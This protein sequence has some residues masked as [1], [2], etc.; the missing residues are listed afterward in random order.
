MADWSNLSR[1]LESGYIMGRQ[2]GGKLSTL[3][4]NIAILADRLKSQREAGEEQ[5]RKINLLGVEGL[6]KEKL[7]EK[8]ASLKPTMQPIVDKTGKI[9]GYR[10]VGAVFQPSSM[11][12][13]D[14]TNPEVQPPSKILPKITSTEDRV[15]VISPTGQKGSIPKSQLQDALKSGYKRIP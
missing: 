1:S 10:P 14:E 9:I 13:W 3:G 12:F 4:K 15:N 6:I 7:L 11:G 8:E 5:G 2:T